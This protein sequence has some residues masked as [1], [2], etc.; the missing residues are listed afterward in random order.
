[1]TD[2]SRKALCDAATPAKQDDMD[3]LRIILQVIVALGILNVWLLRAGKSTPYRGGRA[4]NMRE[5]FQAYGLPPFM[6]WAVGILKVGLSLALLAGI[7]FPVLVQPAVAGIG[8][9]MLGAFFMHIKVKDPIHKALPSILVLV[10]CV[11]IFLI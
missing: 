6:M 5:E 8:F 4:R 10:M 3:I 1:M 9:L 11:V 2:K 7:W